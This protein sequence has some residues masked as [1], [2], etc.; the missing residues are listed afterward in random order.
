M[1]G[2]LAL[3]S[4]DLMKTHD[5]QPVIEDSG[6]RDVGERQGVG[7]CVGEGVVPSFG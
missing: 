3:N 2:E 5:N 6:R 7:V 1:G 4:Q